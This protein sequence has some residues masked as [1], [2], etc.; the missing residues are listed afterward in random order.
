M[1][2]AVLSINCEAASIAGVTSLLEDVG[3]TVALTLNVADAGSFLQCYDFATM[4]AGLVVIVGAGAGE[5]ALLNAAPDDNF[6]KRDNIFTAFTDTDAA[7]LEA[8]ADGALKKASARMRTKYSRYV[9]KTFNAAVA[10]I[11]PL[12]KDIRHIKKVVVSYKPAPLECDVILRYPASID[13]AEL[14]AL[15]S[16]VHKALGKLV[17]AVGDTDMAHTVCALLKTR[18]KKI[19]FAES[20]TGGGLVSSLIEFPGASEIVAEGIVAYGNE[21]KTKRLKVDEKL[22]TRYSAV[23]KEVAFE[24]S[25]NLL[26]ESGADLSVATTGYAGPEGSPVGEC[27][28]ALGSLNGIHLYKYNFEGSRGEIITQGVKTALHLII[29]VLK[30]EKEFASFFS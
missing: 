3:L 8:F 6:I 16:D 7:S 10:D 11:A 20:F 4:A 25:Y 17:Y 28:I 5:K 27:Y 23:S 19:A 14:E 15:L 29:C 9:F 24:M 2:A 18:G 21:S 12:L 22:L 13:K 1:K 26:A 30:D